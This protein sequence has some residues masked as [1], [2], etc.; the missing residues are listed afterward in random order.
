MRALGTG[1]DLTLRF[2]V[3]SAVTTRMGGP[4][5]TDTNVL[6]LQGRYTVSGRA[7]GRSLDFTAPGAAETFR[8]GQ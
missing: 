8:G 1:L 2:E 5:A 4:L 6:Q 7:S 3:A